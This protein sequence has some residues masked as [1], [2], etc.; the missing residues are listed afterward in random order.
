[1]KNHMYIKHIF[2]ITFLMMC[3]N[4]TIAQEMLDY[5]NCG[6]SNAKYIIEGYI[7]AE[8]IPFGEECSP[9]NRYGRYVQYVAREMMGPIEKIEYLERCDGGN[10][11][12]GPGYIVVSGPNETASLKG[13]DNSL[14]TDQLVNHSNVSIFAEITSI[15]RVDGTSEMTTCNLPPVPEY[16]GFPE[17]SKNCI[18]FRADF[19]DWIT[20]CTDQVQGELGGAIPK[21][22]QKVINGEIVFDLYVYD[23]D[24]NGRLAGLNLPRFPEVQIGVSNN[25]TG[26]SPNCNGWTEM[27]LISV[28]DENEEPL[29]PGGCTFV[30]PGPGGTEGSIVCSKCEEGIATVLD[31]SIKN[32]LTFAAIGITGITG[33]GAT[34]GNTLL[35]LT[36]AGG[37]VRVV[38]S[39]IGGNWGSAL[40]GETTTDAGK[41]QITIP[42]FADQNAK[43]NLILFPNPAKDYV[44]LQYKFNQDKSFKVQIINLQGQEVMNKNYTPKDFKINKEYIDISQLAPGVYILA[45]DEGNGAIKKTKFIVN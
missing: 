39:A 16:P 8:K 15:T 11:Y 45:L 35:K 27:T 13:Y 24:G 38:I 29:T 1:M 32:G 28:T 7:V 41:S 26:G 44:Y 5:G 30:Q 4:H 33:I 42:G 17:C 18:R 37:A 31:S 2:W 22:V 36:G 21:V 23:R 25:G 9:A 19:G 40:C 10:Y 20:Y 43:F 12:W 6:Q 3:F 34:A 14:H